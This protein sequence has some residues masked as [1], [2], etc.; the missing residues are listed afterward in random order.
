MQCLDYTDAVEVE[1]TDLRWRRSSHA[2]ITAML[3]SHNAFHSDTGLTLSRQ[4]TDPVRRKSFSQRRKSVAL[5]KRGFTVFLILGFNVLCA[6][7]D[8]IIKS[9]TDVDINSGQ[10][11]FK[12][13]NSD[14]NQF[15][16]FISYSLL[17]NI[18]I[19]KEQLLCYVKHCRVNK[20]H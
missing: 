10:Q 5:F 13:Y 19:C 18:D 12:M 11:Y 2:A 8:T 20:F 16:S 4:I 9:F 17:S 1:E 7:F 3:P 6:D 15:I 14:M